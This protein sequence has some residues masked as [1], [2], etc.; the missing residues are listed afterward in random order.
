M[1]ADKMTDQ[2][3]EEL[4]KRAGD[5][6]CEAIAPF[7]YEYAQGRLHGEDKAIVEEHLE[8]CE[9][10]A[11]L[12]DGFSLWLADQ[13]AKERTLSEMAAEAGKTVLNKLWEMLRP[14]PMPLL[15][16]AV[17]H[18]FRL[19]DPELRRGDKKKSSQPDHAVFEL[20]DEVDIFYEPKRDGYLV[21][22]LQD[23]HG[24]ISLLYP[25]AFPEVQPVV[26]KG[27]LKRLSIIAEK[28]LGIVTV[29]GVLTMKKLFD[30]SVED[31]SS[32]Q[33]LVNAIEAFVE[34][35][36]AMPEDAY[37]IETAIFEVV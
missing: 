11:E 16:L 36:A 23:S 31:F 34:N 20:G 29:K 21:M 17:P 33:A 30:P 15:E 22:L 14:T 8:E 9:M 5:N 6:Y 24:D 25:K 28:P 7:I 1:S 27:G 35:V 26:V 18:G 32:K 19:R 4:L 10:C 37:F 13:K 12:H 2:A 3:L